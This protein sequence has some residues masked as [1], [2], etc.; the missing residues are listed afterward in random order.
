M[1]TQAL[2][3]KQITFLFIFWFCLSAA[4]GQ[5]FTLSGYVSDSETGEKLIGASIY[6]PQKLVGT[7]SNEYG[8]YSL[9]LPADTYQIVISYVGFQ[10][11]KIKVDLKENITQNHNLSSSIQ[12]STFEVKASRMEQIQE[13]SQMSAIEI[14]MKQVEVIP[15]LLGERDVLKVIQ[16]LPGVQ[17]GGEGTSGLYVRGGG[18]DQNLILLDGVPVYNA[19]HLFGFFSVFN[20]DAINNVELIKGGFPARYGGR[21]SSVIDIRM[22]EGSQKKWQGTGSIGIISSKLTVEGPLIKD[23]TSLIVSGRRTYIDV[24][25]RPIIRRQAQQ[26][27]SDAVAGYYFYDLNAKINHK[28]SDKSRLYLS[29]YFGDDQAYFR[30][31]YSNTFNNTTFNSS[32]EAG[33]GWGNATTAI[34]WN[35]IISKKVFSNTTFTYSR[36]RFRIGE[37]TADETIEPDTTYGETFKY[38]YTSGIEDFAGKIDFDILPN[39]NHYIKAGLGNIY[40]TFSPGINAFQSDIGNPANNIDTSFGSNKIFAHEPFVYAEDDIKIG[41]R[42]KLNVGMHFSGFISSNSEYFS[43]QPR[44][45]GRFLINENL[46][47]KA[48]YAEMA[49]FIHLLT[50]GTVGL[51]TDLWVPSTDKVKPQ[52]SKQVAV[53]I[54]QSLNGG[55]E[56]SVEGYYKTMQNLIEYKE[57]ASFF[58]VNRNWDEQIEFGQGN[59]YGGEVFLQKKEGKTT[60][61]VGYTLSWTN[62]QFENLNFGNPFPYRY[63]R[64]HDISFVLV[65]QLNDHIDIGVTWVYGTGNAITLATTRYAPYQPQNTLEFGSFFNDIQHFENRNDFRM[66]SYHRLDVGANFK[67]QKKWG[68]RTWSVGA[69]NLYSRRNPFYL[70]FDNLGNETVVKQVSLFPII[71]SISYSFKF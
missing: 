58:S 31:E 48:S 65:H 46:S 64:R 5:K 27:G 45:S 2:P 16:L 38:E 3:L 54:A 17:S 22:K 23:K 63:D 67:K 29:G 32:S 1:P 20:N 68:E 59:S 42:L 51:P 49:Q 43:F 61:W 66:P 41:A 4:F 40:H 47:V 11:Q 50:N 14:P 35:Q 44:V 28:F 36:Y 13:R 33:L 12:L 21:L 60:G 56:L 52:N 6:S 62:R 30:D 7:T 26:S 15:M 71:P 24:L 39:P 25:A 55:F 34:R 9:T 53:G 70:Y 57:G 18:P 19:S 10:S 8:F 37:E 69:Y